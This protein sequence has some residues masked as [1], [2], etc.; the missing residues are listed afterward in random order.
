M[1]SLMIASSHYRK[2]HAGNKFTSKYFRL[3][4]DSNNLGGYTEITELELLGES[5][6][7]LLDTPG[8]TITHSSA[9]SGSNSGAK[10]A[11]NDINTRWAANG[12]NGQW[13]MF[14]F[15]QPVSIYGM[16]MVALTPA[17]A[18]FAAR[19]CRDF[20]LQISDNGINWTT[21]KTWT[22]EINWLAAEKRTYMF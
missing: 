1:K 21:V 14:L 3:F 13:L 16:T 17:M 20:K 2:R 10:V 7:D 11:D 22:N 6:N 18:A 8:L 9:Y 4:V 19:A 5:G 15:L 12:N